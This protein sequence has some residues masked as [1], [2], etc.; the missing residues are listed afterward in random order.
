VDLGATAATGHWLLWDCMRCAPD[1][2]Y[3]HPNF[4]SKVKIWRGSC[5]QATLKPA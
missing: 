4:V 3:R 2:T 5:T 1:F